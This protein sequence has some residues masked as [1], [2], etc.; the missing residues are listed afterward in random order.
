MRFETRSEGDRL[1]EAWAFL[2]T[3]EAQYLYGSLS[4]YFDDEKDPD[5]HCHVGRSGG[6]ELTIAIVD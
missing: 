4:Y 1:I 5:W 6:C 2:T 3:E